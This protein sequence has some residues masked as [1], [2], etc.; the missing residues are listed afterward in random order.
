[1]NK[2]TSASFIAI[3]LAGFIVAGL[4]LLAASPAFAAENWRPAADDICSQVQ[5]SDAL[6]LPELQAL[7]DRTDKLVPEVQASADPAKK[8]YLQKLK[9]A[10]AMFE[11]M[12]ESKK[13][14][15]K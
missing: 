15:G 5:G 8:V 6:S 13:S 7:I 11:F 12:V 10:R 14:A 4:L 3:N 1:M 2:N 9:K